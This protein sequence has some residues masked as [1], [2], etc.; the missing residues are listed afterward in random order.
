MSFDIDLEER[1]ISETKYEHLRLSKQVNKPQEKGGL[2]LG[3]S[4]KGD[5]EFTLES[6]LIQIQIALH[7]SADLATIDKIF[8]EMDVISMIGSGTDRGNAFVWRASTLVCMVMS[9]QGKLDQSLDRLEKILSK[10]KAY[11][12]L[13]QHASYEYTLSQLA[14]TA[15][16]FA[17][18]QTD[19]FERQRLYEKAELAYK[20][21]IEVRRFIYGDKY[22]G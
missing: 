22:E 20:E 17:E 13:N 19:L 21:L 5:S 2:I 11:F 8:Q 14:T 4:I 1:L 18:R 6:Y 3:G 9:Q 10:Q 15:L 16:K 7:S 12:G